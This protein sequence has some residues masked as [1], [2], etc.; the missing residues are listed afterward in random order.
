MVVTPS[1]GGSKLQNRRPS[2]ATRHGDST[3][4]QGDPTQ[5]AFCNL[6]EDS[7]IGGTTQ[8]RFFFLTLA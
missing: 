3:N 1:T 8:S 6:G 4:K 5:M 2:Y 7:G